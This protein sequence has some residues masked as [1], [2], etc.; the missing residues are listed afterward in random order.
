[1]GEDNAADRGPERRA[2][3]PGIRPTRAGAVQ[4]AGPPARSLTE[5]LRRRTDEQLADLLRRRP[6]LALPAPSDLA[7]LANRLGVRTSVQRVVDELD[8]VRLATLE[9]LVLTAETA[10]VAAAARLLPGVDVSSAVD[11]LRAVGLVWGDDDRLHLVA[12]VVEAV[13]PYPAALGRPAAH[14]YAAVSDV[15][16][17]PVLRTLRLAPAGQPRSGASVADVLTDPARLQTL[18]D[19]RDPA[20]RDVLSRLAEGPPVGVVRGASLPAALDE[21]ATPPHRL[22]AHGLLVPTDTQTVE[23]PREVGLALRGGTPFASLPT[24]APAVPLADV[25][26][27]HL[28]TTA[29]LDTVRHVEALADLWSAT[30]PAVLRA[31]GLGIRDLRR[32]ARALDVDEPVAALLVEVAAAAGLIAASHGMDP[33]FL[34]TSEFDTWRR[35]ATAPR[36]AP[37]VA[38]WLGMTRQPGLVGQRDERE[39]LITALGPDAER[40]TIPAL[41]RQVLGVLADLPAGSAPADRAD[42]LARMAWLAPRRANAQWRLAQAV[43]AEADVLGLTA[44]GGLTGYGRAVLRGAASAAVEALDAALPEPVGHFLVQPDLTVIVPGPAVS[45]LADELNAV[46]D[47]ESTGGASVYRVTEASVRRGLDAGRT[48]AGIARLFRERSRTPVPQALTYLVE[49]VAR[50]HGVL[51][52]GPASAYLRCDDEALLSRVLADR[53]VE[54]LGLRRIAPTVV[55]TTAPVAWMLD[56]LRAGGYAPAAETPEGAIVALGT[57]APRAPARPVSRLVRD[58]PATGSAAHVGELIRR[59]R[60]GDQLAEITRRVAPAGQRVP[61]VTSAATLGLLREA[62]RGGR[63]IWLGYVDAHGT[64][65]Q[66]TIEPISMAGGT[67]RGHDVQTGRLEAFALHHITGVGVLE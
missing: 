15:T 33:V 31:G 10:S 37:L 20:E 42:V 35:R 23:L 54:P 25:D 12:H 53:A 34:P 47:L 3:G 50:R 52:T 38:A 6:D 46:A 65:S 51:R 44:A 8:A 41:R 55:V 19:E 9:A 63:R 56:V 4:P 61:G 21:G 62:I 2:A 22:I 67:L 49:D 17:A 45:E 58:R 7:T 14:L 48:G 13:G 36:W 43:L 39:R 29:V 40:G 26:A 32:A 60:A 18:L 57:D 27:D 66:R 16:L 30:P 24:A 64:S 11:E 5:W 1:M 59:L 28:G